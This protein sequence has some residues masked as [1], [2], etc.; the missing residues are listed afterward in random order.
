MKVDFS[1]TLERIMQ[2]ENELEGEIKKKNQKIIRNYQ[3][4]KVRIAISIRKQ[5]EKRPVM[6]LLYESCS[7]GR[8]EIR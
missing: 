3:E 7:A 1:D 6:V 5:Q 2:L 4:Q 8:P